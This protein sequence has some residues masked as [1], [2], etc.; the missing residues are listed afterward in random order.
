[1]P[2]PVMVAMQPPATRRYKCSLCWTEG[3]QNTLPV[4]QPGTYT[5]REIHTSCLARPALFLYQM[6]ELAIIHQCFAFA[7]ALSFFF[8]CDFA[9]L[10]FRGL[11]CTTKR[12]TLRFFLVLKPP[13]VCRNHPSQPVSPVPIPFSPQRDKS[14]IKKRFTSFPQI[15][16]GCTLPLLF[17]L[18]PP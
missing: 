8:G 7:L 1:M 14:E 11:S 4:P 9:S 2:H 10:I 12:L 16:T 18:P 15:L 3:A 17:P 5:H 6:L 13:F